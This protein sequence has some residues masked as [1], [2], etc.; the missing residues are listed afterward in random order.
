MS[1]LPEIEKLISDGLQC[2]VLFTTYRGQKEGVQ[3]KTLHIL[4]AIDANGDE[5]TVLV[6]SP[7][8]NGASFF[9]SGS[10]TGL[11]AKYKSSAFF[12][13]KGAGFERGQ[14]ST[15]TGRITEAFDLWESCFAEH[16]SRSNEAQRAF[17]RLVGMDLPSSFD[18]AA[19]AA[20]IDMLPPADPKAGYEA[21]PLFGML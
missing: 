15:N 4:Q 7:R 21:Q 1:Y 20:G 3:D 2:D 13:L 19:A 10:E 14:Q 6:G 12:A 16:H 17:L 11:L 8:S 5:F 9:K 18:A